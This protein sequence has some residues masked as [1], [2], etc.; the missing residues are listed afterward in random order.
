MKNILIAD[1]N[2]EIREIVRVLLES[3]GYNIIEAVDGEDAVVKVNENIDLIILDIMMPVKS[4]FKACIEIREK[5]SAP[6]LLLTAKTQDSDKCMGFSSGCDDYLSKPFS[7]T[8]LVSR[9]KALLRR[10]YVY[11]G[12]E[13]VS[14]NE[15]INIEELT[16]NTTSNEV[17]IDNE[18][19]ILTETEYEIL[20]LMANHRKKVFSAQNLYESVWKEPYFYSCNNTIMVHI[21]N[22]RRKLEKDPQ[23][24]RYIKTI[25]GKGYRIE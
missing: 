13:K 8:E 21:R 19:V 1:D 6:I 15:N 10:Y 24:P 7:Y 11:K 9:V 12:K 2:E 14:P 23:N 22:L 5:T 17:L 20:L 16:I 25:W 4:G 3:E 18:E